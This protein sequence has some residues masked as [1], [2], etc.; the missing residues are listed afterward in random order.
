MAIENSKNMG[1]DELSD[2]LKL[3][4]GQMPRLEVLLKRL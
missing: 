2:L 1:E 3:F 4:S